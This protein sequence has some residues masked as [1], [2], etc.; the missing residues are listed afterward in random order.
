MSRLFFSFLIRHR[1]AKHLQFSSRGG[2]DRKM[3]LVWTDCTRRWKECY[4]WVCRANASQ[5]T[6]W[7]ERRG[8]RSRGGGSH[9]SAVTI[10]TITGYCVQRWWQKHEALK[11][12]F[13]AYIVKNRM[14]SAGRL[15]VA[16]VT[17][18]VTWQLKHSMTEWT[19]SW[20]IYTVSKSAESGRKHTLN[21]D[22]FNFSNYCIKVV[23]FALCIFSLVI[24]F[25]LNHD[26]VLSTIWLKIWT[27]HLLFCSQ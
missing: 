7:T 14:K 1:N 11:S 12:L 6:N 21:A 22:T 5:M 16:A 4:A 26:W 9:F 10:V 27:F 15:V 8:K 20:F 17:W 18:R 19:R 2:D 25:V 23:C 3:S 13:C 24:Y